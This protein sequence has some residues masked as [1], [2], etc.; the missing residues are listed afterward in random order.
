MKVAYQ[1]KVLDNFSAIEKR[2]NILKEVAEGK[3]PDV[4]SKQAINTL[5]EINHLVE[6]CRSLVEL[7]QTR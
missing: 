6:S 7:V 2:V 4:S 3:R 5:N 1:E